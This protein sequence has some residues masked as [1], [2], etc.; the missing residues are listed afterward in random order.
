MENFKEIGFIAAF[1]GG[2]ISFISPCTLPVIL[3][4]LS[5]I[6]GTKTLDDLTEYKISR[7]RVFLSSLFFVLGFS[8][9]YVT[10][11]CTATFLGSLLRTYSSFLRISSG[12]LIILLGF[13]LLGFI[14]VGFLDQ[15]RRMQF[16]TKGS[17]VG[18]FVVGLGFSIGWTPC[19]GPIIAGIIGLAANQETIT[20][21]FLLLLTY[22]LG[23]GIPFVL[24]G[25]T[26]NFFLDF[27]KKMQRYYRYV[28]IFS[29]LLLIFLGILL[30]RNQMLIIATHGKRLINLFIP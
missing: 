3:P 1:I 22:S 24:T 23:L 25:L 28:N 13:Y 7:K 12:I 6:T 2:L 30:L 8:V 27:H 20:R 11:G 19:Y 5:F 18:A 17:Y 10:M 4:Y 26:V 21:G 14:R 9:V 15:N 29:G 16:E